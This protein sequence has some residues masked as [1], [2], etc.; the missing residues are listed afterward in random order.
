MSN[1][2]KYKDVLADLFAKAKT[3]SNHVFTSSRPT[4][5]ER[6]NSFIVVRL[7]QGI[8]PYADTHNTAYV[9]MNCFARDRQ[10]GV[11]NVDEMERLINGIVG[12]LPFDDE[13][14]SCNDK[15]LVLNTKSD[16]MGFH[17]TIIQF[18]VVIK[19]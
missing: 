15:A 12:L 17:S 16:G 14:L 7:P 3:V 6:M 5:T 4:A 1:R 18:K 19:V 10:G 2:Y 9:Q 8:D 11:E 13:L